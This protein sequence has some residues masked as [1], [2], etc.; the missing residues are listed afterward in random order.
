M[1]CFVKGKKPFFPV[2][3][4]IA[5]EIPFLSTH[6]IAFSSERFINSIKKRI[7]SGNKKQNDAL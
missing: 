3:W 1:T 7:K 6:K 5:A 2:Y 4:Q